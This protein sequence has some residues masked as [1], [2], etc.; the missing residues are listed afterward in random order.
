MV[1]IVLIVVFVENM[2]F[3][4]FSFLEISFHSSTSYI[5]VRNLFLVVNYDRFRKTSMLNSRAEQG[6]VISNFS[7]TVGCST[8]SVPITMSR[9]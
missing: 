5:L 2:F 7:S 9:S 8:P 1:T 4:V 6:Y 3:D